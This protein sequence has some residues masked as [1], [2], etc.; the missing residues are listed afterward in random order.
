MGESQGQPT[1]ASTVPGA[2]SDAMARLVTTSRP[3]TVQRT[4]GEPRGGPDGRLV[5]HLLPADLS[6]G[7]QVYAR[8]LRDTL[9]NRGACHRTMTLFEAPPAALL[10]DFALRIPPRRLRQHGLDP[11]AVV[12]LGRALRRLRPAVIVAHGGEPL[13][14]A[15]LARPAS[16]IAYYKIGVGMDQMAT[17][18]H[19]RFYQF[20]IGR[21]SAVIAI[22]EDAEIELRDALRCPAKNIVVIP[23]GRDASVYRPSSV[24]GQRVPGRLIA[25]G[26]LT[27]DKRPEVF[28]LVVRQ[29]R[30][31]GMPVE[32]L[33]VGDGPLAE[34]LRR[35]AAASG[36]RLMGRRDDVPALMQDSDVLVMPSRSKAEG[37]PGVLIEAGLCGLPAVTTDIAGASAI[38]EHDVTGLVVPV[39]DTAGL[40]EGSRRLMADAALRSVMGAAARERCVARFSLAASAAKWEE[41]LDGVMASSDGTGNTGG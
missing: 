39:D 8:M 10:P 29:L 25:V 13:K 31:A 11:R 40:V 23:N 33:L 20:L 14:Y 3:V 15:V 30:H 16:A 21:A 19:S 38:V 6:R 22:S 4:V 7:A 35:S 2:R 18:L 37:S 41:L 32:G 17:R 24:H 34:S 12:R 27:A 26:H 9:D 28:L 36:V 5:L 1:A